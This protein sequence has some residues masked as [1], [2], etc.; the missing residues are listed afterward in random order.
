MPNITRFATPLLGLATSPGTV[1]FLQGPFCAE[2]LAGGVE[3]SGRRCGSLRCPLRSTFPTLRAVRAHRPAA[4]SRRL[5]K[6]PA[7]PMGTPRSWSWSWGKPC[8]TPWLPTPRLT[9]WWQTMLAYLQQLRAGCWR[10]S[11]KDSLQPWHWILV[12]PTTI[13]F[14]PGNGT[15]KAKQAKRPMLAHRFTDAFQELQ[16]H[17]HQ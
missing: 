17:Q 5:Q 2:N 8:I 1:P 4:A 14:G 15:G 11:S 7:L 13:P 3:T 16:P 12:Q 6:H 9:S 10:H